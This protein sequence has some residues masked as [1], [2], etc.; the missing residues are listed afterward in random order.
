MEKQPALANQ[1][2]GLGSP[3][4]RAASGVSEQSGSIAPATLAA[5]VLSAKSRWSRYRRLGPTHRARR[6][7]TSCAKS[8]P[9]RPDFRNIPDST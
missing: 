5:V 2:A 4:G 9:V 3:A 7:D 8:G 6:D 1:I